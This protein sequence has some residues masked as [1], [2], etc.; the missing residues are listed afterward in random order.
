MTHE[1]AKALFTYADGSLF[2]VKTGKQAGSL[3]RNGYKLVSHKRVFVGLH[4]IIFLLHHGYL[5]EMVDHI[6]GD[7]NNNRIENLRAATRSQN[8]MNS[9]HYA[10]NTSG[11]RN[12]YQD[13]NK[14]TVRLK[15]GGKLKNFGSYGDIELAGLV[16]DEARAKFYGQF[17][18]QSLRARVAQLEAK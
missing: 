12:V 8:N 11:Y 1:E 4:R 14:F 6:D 7:I 17:A 9:R 13:K 15:V 18:H 3:K 10:N 5:P 16:A 2:W